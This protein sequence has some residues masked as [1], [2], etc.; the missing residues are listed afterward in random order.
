MYAR[1]NPT[2]ASSGELATSATMPNISA[3]A[4]GG[5]L[6]QS[7]KSVSF[8]TNNLETVYRRSVS[9]EEAASGPE[10]SLN[11]PPAAAGATG[12]FGSS[13]ITVGPR[14]AHAPPM[15]MPKP[16]SGP[17]NSYA[18]PR[19]S[20]MGPTVSVATAVVARG[21]PEEEMYTLEP[22]ATV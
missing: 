5:S 22:K 18:P 14:P 16:W 20:S 1:Y 17:S 12:G 8:S 9:G 2:F 10:D 3:G 11:S 7:K 4:S 13:S 19:P 21:E 15:P 6:A